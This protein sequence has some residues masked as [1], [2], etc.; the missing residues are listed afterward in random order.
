MPD[1]LPRPVV[2]DIGAV[3]LEGVLRVP[4]SAGGLV[5]FAHGSGS[6]RHS[7]RNNYVAQRLAAAGQATLLFDLLTVEEE[8][9]DVATGALRFDV[10]LLMQRLLAATEWAK[11]QPG[12][13]N[14]PLGY[15]G[16]STGAAAALAA[17]ASL[18]EV[19]AVV[20]RG[21]RPDLAGPVLGNVRAPT[22]LIV[23]GSDPQVL[24]LNRAALAQLRCV[25]RLEIIAGATH[26]FEQSGALERVADLAGAWFE[27][28]LRAPA[29]RG[30]AV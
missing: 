14:L 11:R 30:Q 18:S 4:R 5:L 17:A 23:G 12:T 22:L 1:V 8:Q 26:L 16:A 2:L 20:S 24:A 25:A 6:G 15:F 10:A 9:V 28:Y 29:A 13:G 3:T 7:P 21:G 19:A 27:R